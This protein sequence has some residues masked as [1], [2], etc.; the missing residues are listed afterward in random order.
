VQ[1]AHDREDINIWVA[2]C[3]CRRQFR[4]PKGDLR[5]LLAG[6]EAVI[7]CAAPKTSRPELEMDAAAKRRIQVRARVCGRLVDGEIARCQEGRNDTTEPEAAITIR[8]RTRRPVA[9]ANSCG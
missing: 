1:L 5:H 2:V 8:F 4:A 7:V 6:A 9:R 3:G